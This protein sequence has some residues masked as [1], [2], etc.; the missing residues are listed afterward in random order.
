MVVLLLAGAFCASAV[1]IP[2][3]TQIQI[4]L[5]T[6]VNSSKAKVGEPFEAVVIAPVVL[7][8]RLAI[9]A[10]AKVTGHIKAVTAATQPDD[11]ASL[12]LAFDQIGEAGV[13]ANIAAKLAGVDNAR[14]TIDADGKIQGIIASQTGSARLDQGIKKVTEKYPGFGEI[15][16]TIKDTV[17]KETD[18]NIDYEPGVEMSIELTRGLNWTGAAKWPSVKPIE[19]AA[20]LSSLVNGE[21]FRTM[22]EKPARP[23]D[24]TNLM[25]LG[26]AEQVQ[27]AFEKAGW[28][29]AAQLSARSKLETFR[30]MA[31]ER[32]Y[33]EAPVSVLLLD[34]RP[35][36]M[37]L[38]KLNDTFNARH[39]LRIFRRPGDFNGKP[40]WVCSATHDTGIDFSEKDRTFIHKI[41]SHIDVER[42]KVVNDLLFTGLVTGVSL[43]D[44][45]IPQNLFNATGDQLVTDGKMAVLSF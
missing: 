1:Q 39:H 32:G 33:Q 27:Q 15:L 34:G 37:V 30:A 42:A 16:G 13:K 3:G 41:D 26:T 4:R 10:G 8:D 19:P 43:V 6:A 28:A 14:E 2:A 9:A 17:L 24:I 35:P 11:Q 18:A 29:T 36:D 40:V 7:G 23:S 12:E 44:R 25:F 31:E 21:P 22:A 38:E 5:T 20:Q 45:D